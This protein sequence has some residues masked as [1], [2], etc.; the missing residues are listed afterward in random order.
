RISKTSVAG[1]WGAVAGTLR[2]FADRSG[3]PRAAIEGTTLGYDLIREYAQWGPPHL[4]VGGPRKHQRVTVSRTLTYFG[5]ELEADAQAVEGRIPE[6]LHSA[7]LGAL[8]SAL[9]EG[10]TVH[11]DQSR[12]RRA[13]ERLDE[14][15][16]RSGG[17]IPDIAPDALR[18]RVR[19]QLE[20]EGVDGWER[21]IRSRI[22]IDPDELVN[23][24]T[25]ERLD[26]LP[27]SIHLKG[28]AVPLHYE[29]RGSEPVVRLTL[30]EGQARRVRQ[31]DLPPL[32]RPL[33]FGARRGAH[34]PLLANTLGELQALLQRQPAH[35]ENDQAGGRGGDRYRQRHQRGG[36]GG[37][38]GGG[39]GGGGGNRRG[40][41]G[42]RGRPG[43]RGK[44]SR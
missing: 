42:G 43:G 24:A 16:R 1:S 17:T 32:D 14:W 23:E 20:A 19:A 27:D 13:L 38:N 33:V 31:G 37:R 29:L 12:L 9:I 25:A 34:A 15:W 4:S 2:F 7:A 5:F 28:D 30:R 18:Q 22:T 39:G 26:A 35:E 11:P 41:G 21:F 3:T 40:P 6:A 8:A 10:E 36:P 44:R